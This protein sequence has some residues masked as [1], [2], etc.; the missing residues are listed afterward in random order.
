MM[1]VV[2]SVGLSIPPPIFVSYFQSPPLKPN[3]S[4]YSQDVSSMSVL[5]LSSNGYMQM[6]SPEDNTV[7]VD[8]FMSP[9][10]HE[11]EEA[12]TCCD[13]S[14][15]GCLIA[16][17]TTFGATLQNAISVE[18]DSDFIVNSVRCVNDTC[19]FIYVLMM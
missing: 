19:A 17:G 10:N 16:T 7:A 8:Y 4:A 1:R 9:L 3:S 14:S 5:A 18:V 2:S 15:S 12:V 13:V 6:W 11:Q